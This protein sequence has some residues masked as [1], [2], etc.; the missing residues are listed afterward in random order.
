MSNP[1]SRHL[2]A[3]AAATAALQAF[4]VQRAQAAAPLAEK[5]NPGWYRYKVG[6]FEVTDVTDGSSTSPLADNYIGNASK[7]DINATLAANHL[8]PY[9]VTHPY[10]PVAVNTAPNLVVIATRLQLI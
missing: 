10:S 1:T 4:A 2:L 5:Q 8:P 3:G 6:S 9:K 7:S